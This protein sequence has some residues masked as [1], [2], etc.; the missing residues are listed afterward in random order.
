MP[1]IKR[2]NNKTPAASAKTNLRHIFLDT[3]AINNN[4]VQSVKYTPNKN[5][6]KNVLIIITFPLFCVVI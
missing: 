5:L 2:A 1:V 4:G 6:N 3:R